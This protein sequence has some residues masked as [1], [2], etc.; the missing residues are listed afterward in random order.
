L[1]N[2]NQQQKKKKKKEKVNIRRKK[3]DNGAMSVKV[4]LK[5]GW[6]NTVP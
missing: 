4:G 6:K 2:K 3:V 5:V 1:E